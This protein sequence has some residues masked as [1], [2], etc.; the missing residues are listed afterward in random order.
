M[1]RVRELREI[2]FCS[3]PFAPGCSRWRSA[4]F[5]WALIT[6]KATPT[7]ETPSTAPT[8]CR[9]WPSRSAFIGQPATVSAIVT[10]T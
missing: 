10:S 7:E 5:S 9:T 6:S 4:V 8:C 3:P 2:D 1:T